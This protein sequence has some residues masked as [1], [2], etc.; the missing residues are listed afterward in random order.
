[1][2]KKIFFIFLAFVFLACDN[3]AID[4]KANDSK[5]VFAFNPP[6]T[7]L[8]ELL[9][10]QGII[11]L[12]YKPYPEDK[13]FM[14]EN[15]I[16]LPVLGIGS[17]VSFEQ[18]VS[19]KPDVLI[20]L[21]S[22]DDTIIKPYEK[23]GIKTIKAFDYNLIEENIKLYGNALG[24]TNRANEL[25]AFYKTQAQRLKE[26][27]AKVTNRPK[28]Y[29]ALGFDG[30]Q[31]QCAKNGD[32]YDLA[33]IIG[34]ENIIKCE[35]IT[36]SKHILS[37]N[38]EL[39]IKLNP[40]IIFVREIALYKEL[41]NN[42]NP[43]WQRIDAIKNDRIYYA[44]SSPS[45]WLLRPPSAM[46]IIGYPWAFSRVHPELLSHEEAKTI[47]QDFFARFLR[48]LSDKDYLRLEAND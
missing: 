26:L 21:D 33:T 46:S 36:T 29:F 23:L 45:N 44:P 9:Y 4:T 24:V 34:G 17:R 20:F 19:L 35:E 32:K 48:P 14:P 16:D 18:I 27:N 41:K 11:G 13:D 15:I 22:T 42:P 28:I 10:P 39:I 25:I 40:Q 8:L 3:K 47:A 43:Q 2:L 1:M 7:V 6:L 12:N 37:L 31:S 5:R 38:H 30:L